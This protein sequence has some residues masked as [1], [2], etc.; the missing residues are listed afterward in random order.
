[1]FDLSRFS[2]N[3]CPLAIWLFIWKTYQNINLN[4]WAPDSFKSY[5][6]ASQYSKRQIIK[7]LW[8]NWSS[9]TKSSLKVLYERKCIIYII[10]IDGNHMTPLKDDL[11]INLSSRNINWSFA[12]SFKYFLKYHQLVNQH[13]QITT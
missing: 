13:V 5:I 7:L 12:I 1:M 6:F 3:T 10:M 2:F 9:F 8:Y 4:Q 11:V